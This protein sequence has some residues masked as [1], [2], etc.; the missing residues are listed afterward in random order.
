MSAG[1]VVGHEAHQVV[2]AL[3]KVKW[4]GLSKR[5]QAEQTMYSRECFKEGMRRTLISVLPASILEK[6]RMLFSSDRR[7]LAEDEMICTHSFCSRDIWKLLSTLVMP[8]MAFI[9]VLFSPRSNLD[10]AKDEELGW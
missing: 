10:C 1:G 6:S 3:T 7:A 9:G 2:D 8:Q 5:E 4:A